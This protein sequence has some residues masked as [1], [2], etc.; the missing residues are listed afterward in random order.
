[1]FIAQDFWVETKY[2]VTMPCNL[3]DFKLVYEIEY[4]DVYK[5]KRVQ[6]I[7]PRIAPPKTHP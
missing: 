5:H 2:F 6:V 4:L 1:M 7:S 3:K